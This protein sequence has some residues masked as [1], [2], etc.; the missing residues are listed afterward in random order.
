MHQRARI[1]IS[2]G[3]NICGDSLRVLIR[4][5]GAATLVRAQQ[6]TKE[7]HGKVVDEDGLPISRVE[8]T[9]RWGAD[10]AVETLTVYTDAV[11]EFQ[12]PS[13]SADK[14]TFSLSKPGYFRVEASVLDLKAGV[15]DANLN[16]NHETELSQKVEVRSGPVQ[17]D[18]NTTSHQETLVQHEVLNTPVPSSHDLQQ[19]LFTMPNVLA[20]YERTDSYCRSPPGTNGN[21]AGRI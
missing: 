21:S 10:A 11:G 3:K 20:G 6:V 2:S 13:I 15:N 8:V 16:L 9:A 14:I 19:S 7:V 4:M 18:P 5:V 17:I 12:I 1:V